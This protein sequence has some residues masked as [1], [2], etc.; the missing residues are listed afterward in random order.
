MVHADVAATE[1]GVT[2]GSA[3]SPV[4]PTGCG[5]GPR[6]TQHLVSYRPDRWSPQEG[7]EPG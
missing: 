3:G 2:K 7:A 4:F 6:A 1:M 5:M